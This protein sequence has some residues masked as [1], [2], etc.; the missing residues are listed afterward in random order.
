MLVL[1]GAS[2]GSVYYQATNLYHTNLCDSLKISIVGLN[3]VSQ[4]ICWFK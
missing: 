2:V 1:T 4:P 3:W